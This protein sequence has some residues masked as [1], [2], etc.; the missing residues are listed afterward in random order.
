MIIGSRIEKRYLIQF[1]DNQTWRDVHCRYN[2][3]WN[4]SFEM[5]EGNKEKPSKK[6]LES[7]KIKESNFSDNL[8]RVIEKTIIFMEESD[9]TRVR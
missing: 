2:G 4:S 9:R 8:Y 1:C 3:K 6:D 5:Y 7:A